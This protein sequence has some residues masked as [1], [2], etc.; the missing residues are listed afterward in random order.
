MIVGLR[1][2]LVEDQRVNG[3]HFERHVLSLRLIQIGRTGSP[4]PNL[5]L[6]VVLSVFLL[7]GSVRQ[8]ARFHLFR[9]VLHV[10]RY[11]LY[12]QVKDFNH[13]VFLLQGDLFKWRLLH[14]LRLY[15]NDLGENFFHFV[16]PFRVLEISLYRSLSHAS[17]LSF[18]RLRQGRQSKRFGNRV[19]RLVQQCSATGQLFRGVR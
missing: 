16:F 18:V 4:L 15:F 11:D 1:V 19:A 6:L 5:C 13:F 7:S 2:S 12:V 14:A 9:L 3:I 10:F 8:D 17:F